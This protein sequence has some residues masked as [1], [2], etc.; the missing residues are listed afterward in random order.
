MLS[1]CSSSS[2]GNS[3]QRSQGMCVYVCMCRNVCSLIIIVYMLMATVH[4]CML[5]TYISLSLH[6]A[7]NCKHIKGVFTWN[8]LL[9][10]IVSLNRLYENWLRIQ[11]PSPAFTCSDLHHSKATLCL[12]RCHYEGLL[13][14]QAPLSTSEGVHP[15]AKVTIRFQS[16]ST[17]G[18][19]LNAMCIQFGLISSGFM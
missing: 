13:V 7:Y 5:T 2:H 3:P 19:G 4:T 12:Q 14:C 11:Y 16:Q 6:C 9:M 1:S 15:C 10:H 8:P 17:S 18:G